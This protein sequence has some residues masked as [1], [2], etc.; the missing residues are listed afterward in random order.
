[1]TE[2]TRER[3]FVAQMRAAIDAETGDGPYVSRVV[4]E[5][6]VHKLRATDPDLL[7]GWLHA[8][9]EHF[10]WQAINDRD[11]ST[12][13]RG[14]EAAKRATFGKAAAAFENGD[15]E[16]LTQFLAMPFP[17]EGGSR[18]RLADLTGD[19]LAYVADDYGRRATE[20][21]M[22]EAFLRALAKRVQHGVVADHFTEQ[23]L[24]DM[25]TSLTRK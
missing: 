24:A 3:D 7:D 14:K 6:I 2:D 17:V 11:R 19:D 1:M 21:A 4:A 23:Q 25:W 22:T 18:K 13:A 9:A 20:N 10:L 15:T 8:Q 5:H 12:R 16:P